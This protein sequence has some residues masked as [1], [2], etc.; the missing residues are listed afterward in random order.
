MTSPRIKRTYTRIAFAALAAMVL[1]L[2]RTLAIPNC[3]ITPVSEAMLTGWYE[4]VKVYGDQLWCANEYGIV[5]FDL[6]RYQPG[7]LPP[8]IAHFPTEGY[9]AA[10]WKQDSIC[11]VADWAEGLVI[12]DVSDLRHVREI[13]HCQDAVPAW[14]VVVAN[15]SAFVNAYKRGIYAIDVR[16]LNQPQLLGSWRKLLEIKQMVVRDDRLWLSIPPDEGEFFACLTALNV[17][18]PG[19]IRVESQFLDRGCSDFSFN[20]DYCFFASDSSYS[21]DVSD[22]N[23]M[24]LLDALQVRDRFGALIAGSGAKFHNGYLY[25]DAGGTGTSIVDAR[26][27]TRL[28]Y[29][30][31]IPYDQVGGRKVLSIYSGYL[32]AGAHKHGLKIVNVANPRN[33]ELLAFSDSSGLPYDVAIRGNYMYVSDNLS[34]RMPDYSYTGRFR[35][36]DISDIQHPLQ[37][38]VKDSLHIDAGV[39]FTRLIVRDTIAYA[40][41]GEFLDLAIYSIANPVSPELLFI[42]TPFDM[43]AGATLHQNGIMQGDYLFGAN[44]SG[45][46]I[47]SVFNPRHAVVTSVILAPEWTNTL[48]AIPFDTALYV[49]TNHNMEYFELWPYTW[50]NPTRPR[51]VG[52]VCRLPGYLSVGARY[53][54]YLYLGDPA[55]TPGITVVSVADR[56]HPEVVFRSDEVGDAECIRVFGDHLFVSEYYGVVRTLSLTEPDHPV[57]DGVYDTPG[58]PHGM[59]VDVDRGFM[60]LAD[61]T[62]VTIYDVGRILGVW[63][64]ALSD[65]VLD[66][67]TLYADSLGRRS[68]QIVNN[69]DHSLTIDSLRLVGRGF[70]LEDTSRSF[71]IDAGGLSEVVVHFVPD[72]WGSYDG[73]LTLYSLQRQLHVRLTA[74]GDTLGVPL[75]KSLPAKFALYPVSPNPFNSSTTIR[76]ALPHQSKLRLSILDLAGRK[77]A[78]LLDREEK[79]GYHSIVW[80]GKSAEGIPVTSGMYFIRLDTPEFTKVNKM[81][82]VK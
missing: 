7:T 2:G 1:S 29:C 68:F 46:M 5:I 11:Y 75:D 14:N 27:P 36:F 16:N 42:P 53:G 4:D 40:G 60:A 43:P 26:D 30:G 50:R 32:F 66:F 22:L 21:L 73:D 33:P 54:N 19:N 41:G 64:V 72:G 6:A 31:N 71:S 59:D 49:T 58:M 52:E 38:A 65:T 63:N 67:G 28:D 13:G 10:L 8:E 69:T 20:D 82:F 15:G 39:Q 56:L 25:G 77:V 12:Y 34:T 79:T 61:E 62:D 3:N 70:T 78:Q 24:R 76:Y 45:F 74:S 17:G 9:A 18:D 51:R 81:V 55:E 35:V 57:L 44:G 23:N 37:I 48:A 80:D 47:T